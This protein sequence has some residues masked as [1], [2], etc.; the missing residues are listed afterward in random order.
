MNNLTNIY[1]KKNKMSKTSSKYEHL[2]DYW[3]DDL[4]ERAVHLFDPKGFE[5]LGI[6]SREMNLIRTLNGL[7]FVT[8]KH[9][10]WCVYNAWYAGDTT[11]YYDIYKQVSVTSPKWAA[12]LDAE[13]DGVVFRYTSTNRG[14]FP[15]IHHYAML[16]AHAES[17]FINVVIN[18]RD[19]GGKPVAGTKAAEQALKNYRNDLCNG[20]VQPIMDP[21][22][23]SVK[24]LQSDSSLKT[25]A[26]DALEVMENLLEDFYSAI[27]VKTQWKKKG[28]AL[29]GEIDGNNAMLTQVLRDSLECGRESC[30]I[31]NE[32][33]GFHTSWDLCPELKYAIDGEVEE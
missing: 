8:D 27:G 7:A 4:T 24:I 15:V 26:K 16:L 14:L 23:A 30:R 19:L 29:Q 5:E 32:K 17:S 2:F 9:E 18:E 28:N 22:F 10:G 12:V 21:G 3:L 33:Y 31:L 13:K 1:F 11:K 25:N 6:P 20:I